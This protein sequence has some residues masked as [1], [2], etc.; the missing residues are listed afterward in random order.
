MIEEQQKEILEK[1]KALESALASIERRFGKGSIM[2]LKSAERVKV[3]AIPTGS[4]ALDIATGVGGIPKGK[5]IEIFGPESS[6]K[7][8]LAL[9]VIAEAQKRGGIAVFI[10]AEHA[11]DPKYAQKIGLMWITSTFLSQITENK[12]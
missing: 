6:G 8:T 9:H 10:D 2:P 12:P 1:R 7:T 4:L 3:E 11:L 5:I